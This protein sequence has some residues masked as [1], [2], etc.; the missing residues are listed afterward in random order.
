MTIP[1]NAAPYPVRGRNDRMGSVPQCDQIIPLTPA[2]RDVHPLGT[3]LESFDS[4]LREREKVG[5]P[6]LRLP[7][8]ADAIEAAGC[9]GGISGSDMT[10]RES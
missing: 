7:P 8:C 4:P 10:A 2:V 3:N 1:E 5:H 9:E 6:P